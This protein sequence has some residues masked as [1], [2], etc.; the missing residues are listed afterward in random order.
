[1]SI[2]ISFGESAKFPLEVTVRFLSLK[3]EKLG[4]AS[5]GSMLIGILFLARSFSSLIENDKLWI[6]NLERGVLLSL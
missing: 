5:L 6:F 4:A 2:P 3:S 1:M